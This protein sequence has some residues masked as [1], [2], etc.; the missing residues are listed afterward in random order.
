[1]DLK[2][3]GGR[4][5]VEADICGLPNRARAAARSRS[6]AA[7]RI[8]MRRAAKYPSPTIFRFGPGSF[9]AWRERE[10]TVEAGNHDDAH[11]PLDKSHNL[12]A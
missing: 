5:A 9:L 8:G 3:V 7:K 12:A 2:L 6:G 1:M 10:L 11:R 4:R